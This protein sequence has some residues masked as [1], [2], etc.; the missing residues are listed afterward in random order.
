MDIFKIT[1]L[2]ARTFLG[3]YPFEQKVKQQ[4]ILDLEYSANITPA[5][6]SNALNDTVD[7]SLLASQLTQ[8][9]EQR[10]FILMEALAEQA[11]QFLKQEFQLTWLKL[12]ISKIGCLANA[13][14]VSLCITR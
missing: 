5:S 2:K 10:S 11:A 4:I 8:F 3:T 6:Q 9:I 14:E 12:T 7:Y 1:Q 13:K